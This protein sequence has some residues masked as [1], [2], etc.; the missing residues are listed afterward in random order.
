MRRLGAIGEQPSAR[1]PWAAVRIVFQAGVLLLSVT[2]SGPGHAQQSARQ[3]QLDPNQ[4]EKNLEAIQL[5]HRRTRNT[6]VQLPRAPKPQI[7][8]DTRPLFRLESISVDGAVAIGA[9]AITATYR[10]YLGKTV[11]Q[12]DLSTIAGKI[13]DLYRDAGYHLSRAIVPVQNIAHGHIRIQAIEGSIAE[14]VLKGE[15]A[16]QFGLRPLL[17]A[18]AAEHPSRLGTLE[19]QLLLVNGRPGVQVTDS[20]LEEI[21]T[22][23]GRFRLI[24]SVETWRVF[25]ALGVDSWGTPAVGRLQSYATS[26]LNSYV[27]AGDTLGLNLS[28]IPNAPRELDYGRMS[29]DAPVGANGARLGATAAYGEIWPGDD[30]HQF[31]THTRA[32]TFEV[33][34]S[35]VPLQ[36]QKASLVLSAAAGFSDISERDDLGAIYNDH[37]RTTRLAAD[38]QRQD[39]WGGRNY[40][41]VGW[42]QGFGVLGASHQGDDFLSRDGTGLAS[43]LDFAFAR[44]Q[45]LSDTWSVKFATAG[46]L[47]STTLLESQEFY[48]GGPVFG[49]GY[50]GGEISGDNGV[51][52][53]LEL[54]FDQA[55]RNPI[56]KG[57]QLYGFIDRGT[58]W[59]TGDGKNTL[60]LS[61]AGTGVRLHLIAELEADAG[62]AIPLDYRAIDNESRH[63]HAYFSLVKSFKLCPDRLRMGC[64]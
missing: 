13:S 60:S 41:T 23:S 24:V 64:S 31:G 5:E 3:P 50:Y 10:P 17:A 7:S 6:G 37:I 39:D 29:Y 11:S 54:R 16:E 42:R 9:D 62:I 33:R 55:V 44:Y 47:A 56:L 35:V 48:L 30:R 22:A 63:P 12:A 45:K 43:I 40:L 36:T 26:A 14:I 61:S 25:T 2:A 15:G 4:A 18:V 52:A 51:A 34:G 57:Y 59:D 27:I 8:A 1:S 19:R 21:G 38:Y 20:A 32:E 58:V 53:L 28:T 46:Q 49:R